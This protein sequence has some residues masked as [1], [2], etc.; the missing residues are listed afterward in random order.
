M[1]EKAVEL[2]GYCY[3]FE[4]DALKPVRVAVGRFVQ[5][6]EETNFSMVDVKST[7]EL[8]EAF[9]A[10]WSNIREEDAPYI[11]GILM[12]LRDLV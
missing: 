10:S 9:E 8:L 11:R 7:M 12:R 3:E 2:L 6:H 5:A 1:L 4:G